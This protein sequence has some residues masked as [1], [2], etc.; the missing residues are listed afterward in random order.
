MKAKDITKE[1]LRNGG[2]YNTSAYVHPVSGNLI[3]AKSGLSLY[4]EVPIAD[5]KGNILF[6]TKKDFLNKVKQEKK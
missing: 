4:V 1:Q 6:K 2:M 5:A 3:I